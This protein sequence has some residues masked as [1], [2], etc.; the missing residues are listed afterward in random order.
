MLLDRGH[1]LQ[2]LRYIWQNIHILISASACAVVF[3]FFFYFGF[4]IF[5]FCY[6][7]C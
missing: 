3:C 1:L 6:M 2:R 5:W 7:T 4:V